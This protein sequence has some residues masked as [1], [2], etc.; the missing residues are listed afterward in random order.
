[1]TGILISTNALNAEDVLFIALT[2]SI[3]QKS[4]WQQEK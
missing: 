3:Q 1:M 2:E 4:Q